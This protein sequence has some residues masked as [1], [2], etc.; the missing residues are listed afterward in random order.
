MPDRTLTINHKLSE[1][2]PAHLEV[3]VYGATPRV[4]GFTVEDGQARRVFS[5]DLAPSQVPDVRALLEAAL[6]GREVRKT[7][8]GWGVTLEAGRSQATGLPQVTVTFDLG[9]QRTS[10]RLQEGIL[11]SELGPAWDVSL[12]EISDFQRLLDGE[13]PG[14]TTTVQE[15]RDA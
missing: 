13:R 15:G 8:A 2:D 10:W 4:R 6:A 9:S 5:F 12:T 1:P 14:P 11:R 3:I 7:L